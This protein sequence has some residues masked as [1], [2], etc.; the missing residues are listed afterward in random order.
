MIV[1]F[2]SGK[3][4]QLYFLKENG[5]MESILFFF[6]KLENSLREVKQSF[7]SRTGELSISTKD[8]LVDETLRIQPNHFVAELVR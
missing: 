7:Q 6:G 1:N 5:K 3:W 8:R 4:G 2:S